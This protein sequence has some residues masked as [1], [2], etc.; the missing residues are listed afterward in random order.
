M[1]T[2]QDRAP[3]VP[4]R[5]D[6]FFAE[7][8]TPHGRRAGYH[9]NTGFL[10]Q[11]RVRRILTL[12]G[13]D[14]RLGKPGA[15]DDV[16]VWGHSP[17]APR[18][19]AAAKATGAALVRVEDA[20]LRSLHPGRSGE[21]PL[22]LV[23][24]RSGIHFDATR[25]SDLETLLARHPLDN[26]VLLDR[27][28]DV[29]ARMAEAHLGK[30]AAVDPSLEPPD[31]GF[32]LIVDQTRGDASIR[33]GE[34][35]ADSFAE[36]LTWAR[37]DHPDAILV[38]K[39]HPE[40]QA[41]HRE[42]H[43]DPGALPPGVVI[44]DRPISPWRLFDHA[45]AVYTVSSQL[46]FEAIL[47]GHRPVTFGVPFYAGWGLTD[48]RRPMPARR[49][50]AL[51]RAQLVAA[52]MILYPVWY[53]PYRDRLCPVEDTLAALETQARAWREDRHGYA[54]IGFKDWK[55]A[56]HRAFFGTAGG[57]VTFHKDRG[58]AIGDGHPVQVWASRETDMLSAV[59]GIILEIEAHHLRV[60][61]HRV[62][63]LFP[64]RAEQLQRRRHQ[65]GVVEFRDRRGIHHVAILDRDRVGIGRRDLAMARD[66]LVE[67]HMHQPVILKRVH[68][69]GLDLGGFEK[70]QGFGDRHLV[71]EDLILGQ[72]LLGD[73]VAGLD[74]GGLRCLLGHRDAGGLL[75]E[76][77][78]RYRVG[79]VVRTL[80]DH[81]QRILGRQAGGRDLHT[82]RPPAIGHRHLARGEGHLVARHGDAFQDRAAD[83]PLGL[84]VEIGE[85]VVRHDAPS[86][87]RGVAL[88]LPVS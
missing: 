6:G 52:A 22:G 33:L 5:P 31:P 82:A 34:A 4:D 85:I 70:P 23:I 14:L 45:R 62:D 58:P 18:G 3:A 68:L 83:H 56:H 50:R 78:D 88:E 71:D 35:N 44:E 29:I 1:G 8:T 81:L 40:S 16:L 7:G 48:D 9:F 79:G 59:E 73:A 39:T 24:D 12:A 49:G 47:A 20:F 2:Q 41:G 87:P 19:E 26:T 72:G 69:A 32:V 77:A 53:D 42:G 36:M 10:T 21:P 67:L 75:E 65:L 74:D 54:A 57:R 51:T 66:V 30:Y 60:G 15:D 61:P 25:P 11:P 38:I 63:P 86:C 64:P 28:R 76:L 55:H 43:F 46:G 80:V 27:A 37:Q 17:H 13:H 84:F